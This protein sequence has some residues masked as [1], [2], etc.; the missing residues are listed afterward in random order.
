MARD[1]T[2]SRALS[3]EYAGQA[4]RLGWFDALYR[5]AAGD[6]NAIP[7]ANLAP[8]P[9]LVAFH[10]DHPSA[11]AA[12]HERTCLV[13]GCGLGDDAE[14]LAAAGGRVTAFDL[15]E[16]AVRWCQRR[17]AGSPV[18]Y[19]AADLLAPPGEWARRFD[20]VFE[21]NTLQAL[22]SELRPR[23]IECVAGFVAPGGTLLV[24]CRGRE[25]DEA[26]EGPP[27]P[28]V[29]EE[30]ETFGR[31]GLREVSFQDLIVDDDPPVRRFVAEYVNGARGAR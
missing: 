8:N 18:A 3:A 25:P 20:F 11:A 9:L 2:R 22:P 1:R 26:V 29:R 12:F 6:A 19:V 28:L 24:V 23:A 17:F 30:V 14:Y 13:V 15:S 4:D 27:W 31:F 5:E 7:W 10:A 21:A 16:T